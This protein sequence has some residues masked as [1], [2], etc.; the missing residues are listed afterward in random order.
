MLCWLVGGEQS[1]ST[2]HGDDGDEPGNGTGTW[3]MLV[4]L[5]AGAVEGKQRA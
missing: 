4:L 2:A 3:K 5:W 1:V